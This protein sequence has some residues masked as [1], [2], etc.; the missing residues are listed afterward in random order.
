MAL[1]DSELRC[2]V[3]DWRRSSEQFWRQR[4]QLQ[5]HLDRLS[6]RYRALRGMVA[7][8]A[9]QAHDAGYDSVADYNADHAD[10]HEREQGAAQSQ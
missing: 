7:D 1:D 2:E 9:L 6:E 4:D 3:D 8:V 5:G 10:D